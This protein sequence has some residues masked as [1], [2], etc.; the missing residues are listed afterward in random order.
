MFGNMDNIY[1]KNQATQAS[2]LKDTFELA[3]QM[4]QKRQSDEFQKRTN[5]LLQT[6]MKA[7]D[8]G[9]KEVMDGLEKNSKQLESVLGKFSGFS[10]DQLNAAMDRAAVETGLDPKTLVALHQSL[11]SQRRD[12]IAGVVEYYGKAALPTLKGLVNAGGTKEAM[13]TLMSTTNPI[14]QKYILPMFQAAGA[15]KDPAKFEAIINGQMA[16]TE[17]SLQARENAKAQLEGIV[18][19][20]REKGLTRDQIQAQIDADPATKYKDAQ[21]HTITPQSEILAQMDAA[22]Y[23]SEIEQ[24]NKARDVSI[25]K[26]KELRNIRRSPEY[27]NYDTVVTNADTALQILDQN[28]TVYKN[29]VD[30]ALKKGEATIFDSNIIPAVRAVIYARTGKVANQKE[31][32]DFV[33]SYS[34]GFMTE[35]A[36]AKYKI[37]LL[38]QSAVLNQQLMEES[39]PAR[40]SALLKKDAEVRQKMLEQVHNDLYEG[41]NALRKVSTEEVETGK[42]SS[43]ES[44]SEAEAKGL[45]KPGSWIT[46]ETPKGSKKLQYKP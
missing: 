46:V 10:I 21:G 41:P 7:W 11:E 9:G 39:D 38:K 12:Q 36:V 18:Q 34:P 35:P 22:D 8:K 3:Q 37:G 31:T 28:P 44:L 29:I 26:E 13:D 23:R 17:G 1:T 42:Y 40:R 20:G 19:R 4:Q 45:I 16:A 33:T 15:D 24:K 5:Q 32:A 14:L 2:S 30:R 25:E 6:Q 27:I 43:L